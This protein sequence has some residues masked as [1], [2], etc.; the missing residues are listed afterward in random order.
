MY[1]LSKDFDVSM[2]VGKKLELICFSS[3]TINLSFEED[4]SITILGSFIYRRDPNESKSV[5]KVPVS[6]SDLM[7]LTDQTVRYA[8]A[9]EQGSL[10]LH[11]DNGQD[12]LLLD[13][14]RDYESYIVRIGIKEIIV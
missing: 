10:D 9:C 6:S 14:S 13:D 8:E 3:N 12:L 2:L 5:Q 7:C 11:F 4:V 1:V